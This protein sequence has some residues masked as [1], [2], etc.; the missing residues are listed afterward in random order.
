MELP[1]ESPRRRK[2]PN[3][4][5]M[6]EVGNDIYHRG[7]IN[8]EVTL[9]NI[10]FPHVKEKIAIKNRR[11][12]VPSPVE[13]GCTSYIVLQRNVVETECVCFVYWEYLEKNIDETHMGDLVECH[14]SH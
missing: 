3:D 12:A 9:G 1:S 8:G 7:I 4:Q 13:K 11:I 14:S 10:K 5:V 6:A 2:S